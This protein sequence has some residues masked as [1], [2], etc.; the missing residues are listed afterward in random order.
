MFTTFDTLQSQLKKAEIKVGG[1][2]M[3]NSIE[4]D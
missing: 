4:T 2:K 1:L 3:E